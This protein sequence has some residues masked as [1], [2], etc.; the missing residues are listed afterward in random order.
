MRRNKVIRGIAT[1]VAAL[2]CSGTAM[3]QSSPTPAQDCGIYQ[4]PEVMSPCPEVIIKQ[5]G[6]HHYDKPGDHRT[7]AR[8]RAKGWDTVVT[9]ENRELILSCMPYI[10]AKKFSGTYYVDEIPYD[11]A[12]PTFCQGTAFNINA[13]D[14]FAPPTTIPFPFYFFGLEKNGFVLGSNGMLTFAMGTSG[15]C[16]YSFTS[17]I[18]WN[19]SSTGAPGSLEKMRDAIYGCYEDTHP[20]NS[21]LSGTQGIYYGVQG[22]YPCRKIICSWNE[23]PMFNSQTNNRCTYQIV[24][25]EG[26]NII[27]VHV[28]RRGPG[29]SGWPLMVLGIQNATGNPQTRT[30][31]NTQLNSVNGKPAAFFPQGYNATNNTFTYKSFRFTPETNSATN[32]PTYGWRRELEDGTWVELPR[33]DGTNPEVT[34]DTNGYYEPMDDNSNCKTLTL[35]HVKPKK[36]TRFVFYMNFSNAHGDWYHPADTIYVG[37]DT[38]DYLRIHKATVEDRKPKDLNICEGQTARLRI[39]MTSIQRIRNEEWNLFRVTGGDTVELSTD[40]MEVGPMQTIEVFRIT[41]QG[42]TVVLDTSLFTKRDYETVGDSLQVRMISINSNN[43]P[44]G[45]RNKID[46]LI[47]RNSAIFMTGCIKYD[48]MMLRV[49]PN[50]DTTEYAGICRGD[51]F[52]WRPSDVEHQYDK[53]YTSNT[54]PATTFVT[55]HSQPGC[56][57]TVRLKLTV[58]D[59]SLTVESIESCKPIQ[60]RNGKTYSQNNVATAEHDTVVLQNRY[61]CDSIVQ[62][63]FTIHPL[64]ARLESDVDHFTLDNL[65]ATLTDVSIGGNGRRWIFPNGPEQTSATVY[66]TIPSTE[67]GANIMMIETS[68]YG[69]CV[70]TAK[71]YIPLNKEHFW[72]PNAFMPDNPDDN[73]N[74]FGSVSTKT[75]MQEMLIYNRRGEKVFHCEGI[76]CSWDG[77]DMNGEPCVQGA[78]VYIIRYA[79]EYEPKVTRVIKGTVTLIR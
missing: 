7:Q 41:P 47:V 28:K 19:A 55:L 70:D 72:M 30:N 67:D 43:L 51:T 75:L 6:D 38:A 13:D 12:D 34:A 39:D 18:P 79:N 3:G 25:Y 24:C 69:T 14:Q 29:Y 23:V 65:N 45:Q 1:A 5:K 31:T 20:L 4:W 63:Q 27:E 53:S 68:E 78:Y 59:V 2:L 37:V 54:D 60:W 16:P 56:D 33:Y 8:Y 36:P 64:T 48:T 58:F 44:A 57:S 49:F 42:D 35:A 22:S 61:G 77:K 46:T 21:L 40:L 66:Y 71:I 52:H 11:P 17:G 62:L 9:C 32:T 10:P 74:R 73:L 76:D 15:N 50:F 26:S